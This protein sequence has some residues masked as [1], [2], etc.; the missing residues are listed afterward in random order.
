MSETRE[1]RLAR[2]LR[3]GLD[4]Y[5]ADQIPEAIL[6]WEEILILDPD[7][8]EA[9][10]YLKTAERRENPRLLQRGE[11]SRAGKAIVEEANRAIGQ[12]EF[13]C[14]LDLLGS[15][16]RAEPFGL[17]IHASTEMARS[18]LYRQLRGQVGGLDAVPVLLAQTD[19][20][21]KLDLPSDAGFILSRV[22]GSTSVSDLI[23]AS[24]VD[25]LAALRALHSLVEA[26][27]VGLER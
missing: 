4:H 23:A 25:A 13:E 9:R 22:D 15:A 8:G 10:D 12:G 27:A 21:K 3:E 2:L 20:V 5:G 7:C 19:E 26:G 17:Q 6:A 11:T 16:A 24:G 14:A 18:R 1:E